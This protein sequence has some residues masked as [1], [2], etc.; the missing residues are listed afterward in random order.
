MGFFIG[1]I[2]LFIILI[3]LLYNLANL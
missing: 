1:L 3:L 2:I